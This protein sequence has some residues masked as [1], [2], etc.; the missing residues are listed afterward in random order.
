VTKDTLLP[1]DLLDALESAVDTPLW[2][3]IY[4]RMAEVAYQ[5]EKHGYRSGPAVAAVNAAHTA[6]I[7]AVGGTGSPRTCCSCDRPTS[8]H[9]LCE[10]C[11]RDFL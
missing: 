5:A 9:V 1:V 11:R 8:D 10:Q 4:D 3:I 6:I 2:A 7:E